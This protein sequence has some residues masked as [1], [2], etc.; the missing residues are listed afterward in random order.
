MFKS[1]KYIL[2]NNSLLP[3]FI[4]FQNFN[5]ARNVNKFVPIFPGDKVVV[6]PPWGM[7]KLS[8]YA[9]KKVSLHHKEDSKVQY[10]TVLRVLRK[11]E[12][13]VVSRINE[14]P[15]YVSPHNFLN[16]YENGDLS[17]IKRKTVNLPISIERVRLRD[18]KV[19]DSLK[20]LNIKI[21]RNEAGERIRIRKD[22]G[23]EVP[24]PIRSKDFSYAKRAQGRKD[25]L[26]DTNAS[27]RSIKTYNGENF[28][29][30][31]KFFIKKIQNKEA[32]ES[33]LILKDK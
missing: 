23:T 21:T 8:S 28:A 24:I 16:D 11:K 6:L 1:S 7:S 29:E 32:I 3:S 15:K 19:K 22:D 12:Q 27:I 31:A 9:K 17:K 18:T 5:F 25:G 30:I 4:N 26:K 10:G 33:K 2:G 20:I 13:A 14:K